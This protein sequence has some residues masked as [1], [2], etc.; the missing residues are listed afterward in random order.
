MTMT[1]NRFQ[2]EFDNCPILDGCEYIE[3]DLGAGVTVRAYASHDPYAK[4]E[5]DD[6]EDV[7]AFNNDT[8][9][10]CILRL[11]VYVA[12]KCIKKAAASLHQIGIDESSDNNG[13]NLTDCANELL[14]E[15]D[16]AGIVG[17]FAKK[18]AVAAKAMKKGGSR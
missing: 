3:A 2:T 14:D 8:L 4:P 1:A 13:S 15:I 5:D 9:H 10:F 11:N 12:G 17:D 16:L 18:A 6:P 7:A